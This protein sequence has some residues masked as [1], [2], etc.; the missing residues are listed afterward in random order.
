MGKVTHLSKAEFCRQIA[1]VDRLSQNWTYNGDRP[2]VVDFF[3]QWCGP[4]RA[5]SPVLDRLADEYGDRIYI[6]KVDVDAEQ[7]LASIFGIRSVPTLMFLPVNGKPQI[8]TGLQSVQK[9]HEAIDNMLVPETA[10]H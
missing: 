10:R 5:L 7:E 8:V 3:A 6:Y 9:L 4:C 2:A 1:D